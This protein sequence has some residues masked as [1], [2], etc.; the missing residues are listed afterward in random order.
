DAAATGLFN[1]QKFDMSNTHSL[2]IDIKANH[3]TALLIESL[4]KRGSSVTVAT[5]HLHFGVNLGITHLTEYL[6][7]L[8]KLG[9]EILPMTKLE[10]IRDGSAHLRNFSTQNV[11]VKEFDFIVSGKSARPRDEMLPIFSSIAPTR[12]AGDVV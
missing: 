3:E 11:L 12:T 9:V 1:G 6:R 5:P 2:V 10:A 8:P 7:D 4:A